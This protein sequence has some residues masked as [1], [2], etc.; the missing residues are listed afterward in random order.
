MALFYTDSRRSRAKKHVRALPFSPVPAA[1][2]RRT[3]NQVKNRFNSTLRRPLRQP[4]QEPF[5]ATSPPPRSARLGRTLGKSKRLRGSASPKSSPGPTT[6]SS[7]ASSSS[8]RRRSRLSATRPA[9]RR[10]TTTRTMRNAREKRRGSRRLAN[11]PSAAPRRF[12]TS[13]AR[14]QGFRG[15]PGSPPRRWPPPP[16]RSRTT[17]RRRRLRPPPASGRRLCRRVRARRV[18]RRWPSPPSFHSA[19]SEAPS[20]STSAF[21]GVLAA[22]GGAAAAAAANPLLASLVQAGNP[23]MMMGANQ[24]LARPP[25]RGADQE[26]VAPAAQ[27]RQ[28]CAQR[29]RGF[30]HERTRGYRVGG[31]DGGDGTAVLRAVRA[32]NPAI[33]SG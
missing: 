4:D 29:V 28:G 20:T 13:V 3:D 9:V 23:A 22:F 19:Q 27:G 11:H 15:C 2:H 1:R 12:P 25:L 10:A 31:G 17:R 32:H 33:F 16:R 14:R 21:P 26:R 24:A 8:C 5:P 6:T 7:P 18:S 30:G